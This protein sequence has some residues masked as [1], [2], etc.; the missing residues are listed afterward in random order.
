MNK[1]IDKNILA[2]KISE[3]QRFMYVTYRVKLHSGDNAIIGR[4]V[5]L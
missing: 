4:R 3:D 1:E 5:T 2:A